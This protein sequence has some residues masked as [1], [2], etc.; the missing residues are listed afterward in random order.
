MFLRYLGVQKNITLKMK[1][2]IGGPYYIDGP[3]YVFEID[4]VDEKELLG[5][6][7]RM[8]AKVDGLDPE[9]EPEGFTCAECQKV[10][11]TEGG[12]AS[13]IRQM[14]PAEPDGE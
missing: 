10:L 5:Q 2:L 9:P 6:N 7:P 14:H 1:Y 8:F 3:E 12:L 11:K 4:D 13:H